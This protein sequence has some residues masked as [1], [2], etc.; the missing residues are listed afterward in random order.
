[1]S[2]QLKKLKSDF[3]QEM[4][5]FYTALMDDRI[6]QLPK[7][8]DQMREYLSKTVFNLHKRSLKSDIT[9]VRIFRELFESKTPDSN[10]VWKREICRAD[11]TYQFRGRWRQMTDRLNII[12]DYTIKANLIVPITDGK[13]AEDLRTVADLLI[14]VMYQMFYQAGILQADDLLDMEDFSIF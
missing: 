4:Q 2:L 3:E 5:K 8:L 7:Q 10:M 14:E 11:P 9:T 12:A 6:A 1:M 13:H